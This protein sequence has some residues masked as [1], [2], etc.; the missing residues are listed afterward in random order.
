MAP[1]LRARATGL[2]VS[3]WKQEGS[4]KVKLRA[5][6]TKRREGRQVAVSAWSAPPDFSVMGP[7]EYPSTFSLPSQMPMPSYV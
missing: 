4:L 5:Q 6:K 3:P 7:I 2:M 1:K